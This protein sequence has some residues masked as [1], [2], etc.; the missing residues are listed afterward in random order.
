M[1]LIPINKYLFTKNS[2]SESIHINA[3]YCGMTQKGA[4]TKCYKLQ[5]L[6]DVWP[7]LTLIQAWQQCHMDKTTQL[8]KPVGCFSL[9]ESKL[10]QAGLELLADFGHNINILPFH[11]TCSIGDRSGEKGSQEDNVSY[12]LHWKVLLWH[13]CMFPI[14]N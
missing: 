3:R 11:Q 4:D 6:Y 1:L 10:V 8:K 14:L 9:S 7:P 12:I 5:S 2:N 13:W